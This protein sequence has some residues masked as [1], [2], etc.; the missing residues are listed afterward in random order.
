MA[1]TKFN[2]NT[3]EIFLYDD[4]FQKGYGFTVGEMLFSFLELDLREYNC[5]YESLKYDVSCSDFNELIKKYPKTAKCYKLSPIL[6]DENYSESE[7]RER[8]VIFLT[9]NEDT[10]SS[11]YNHPYFY[12]CEM[13]AW[14][15]EPSEFGELDFYGYQQAIIELIDYCFLEHKN[16]NVNNLTLQ[17]R[18]YLFTMGKINRWKYNINLHI[19]PLFIPLDYHTNLD[20]FDSVEHGNFDVENPSDD[21]LSHIKNKAH[22]VMVNKCSYISDFL[23]FEFNCLFSNNL[24]IKRCK[25][26]GKYFILKGDYSTDYCDRIPNGEKL[27]C[28]K[29]AA[30][31]IRKNKV[32]N[33]PILKEYEKAYK[34]NYAR[35]ANHKT[36]AEE[37]RLWTEDATKERDKVLSKYAN[38]P[39]DQIIDDFKT[40]LG[41]K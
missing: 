39:S 17:E 26:C 12:S 15:M 14:G 5:L 11:L 29:I 10:F 36:T 38:E 33:N 35:Q 23:Y 32:K 2:K 16:P 27:T 34:R 6:T 40:Y 25:N 41:N 8:C 31:N 4:R 24:K 1:Y 18:Y 21:V 30:I 13:V 9:N 19:A 22:A 3:M 37:F 28:K 20:I 7:L